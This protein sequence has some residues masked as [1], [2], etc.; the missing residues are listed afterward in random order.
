VSAYTSAYV[1]CDGKVPATPPN[2]GTRQCP[3]TVEGGERPDGNSWVFPKTKAEARKEARARGWTVVRYPSPYARAADK[4][5]CPACRD[6][7]QAT[8][9]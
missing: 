8:A 6:Q 7:A 3:A 2:H 1:C 5:F 4:D 9:G